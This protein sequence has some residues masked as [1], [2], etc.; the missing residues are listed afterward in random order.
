MSVLLVNN[1]IITALKLDSVDSVIKT[2]HS[3]NMKSL[4]SIDCFFK[5]RRNV[6]PDRYEMNIKI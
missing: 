2:Q 3:K 6:F 1:A 4:Y 5:P